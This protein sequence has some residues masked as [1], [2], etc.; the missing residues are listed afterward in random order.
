[1]KNWKR[2][3]P[4]TTS[5]PPMYRY[6]GSMKIEPD[7]R[8][9]RRLPSISSNTIPTAISTRSGKTDGAIEVMAATPLETDTATVRT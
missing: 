9:P 2:P 6:V 8:M 5:R 7:S 3:T 4:S 1:M